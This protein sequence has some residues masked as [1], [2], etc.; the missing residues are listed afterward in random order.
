MAFEKLDALK[1]M[2]QFESVQWDVAN[3][4]VSPHA[5]GLAVK[6][7][8]EHVDT[9]QLVEQSNDRQPTRKGG[10]KKARK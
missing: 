1:G 7:Q 6:A 4:A 3:E 10:K 8:A 9:L 5:V 2:R